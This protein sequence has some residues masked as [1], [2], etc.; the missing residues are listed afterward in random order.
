M[1]HS[2]SILYLEKWPEMHE[3]RVL[4]GTSIL[5]AMRDKDAEEN[6][7]ISGIAQS[8]SSVKS[9]SFLCEGLSVM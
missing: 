7:C 9:L 5:S 2:L 1:R 3:G 8:S 6:G 4:L